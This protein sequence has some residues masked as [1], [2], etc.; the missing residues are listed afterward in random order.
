M[1]KKEKNLFYFVL[2]KDQKLLVRLFRE[3]C[4]I[5]FIGN[6]K[7]DSSKIYF[8]YIYVFLVF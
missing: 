1:F 6:F 8:K 2:K 5:N 3:Y 4:F 7:L